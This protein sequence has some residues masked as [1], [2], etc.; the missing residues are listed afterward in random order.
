MEI[1]IEELKRQIANND[2]KAQN[3]LGY[4][5]LHGQ[6]IEQ[7]DR[8][9]YELFKKAA[10]QGLI[11]AQH[12][13]GNCYALGRGTKKNFKKAVDLFSIGA[14]KG[15]DIAVASMENLYKN[16]QIRKYCEEKNYYFSKNTTVALFDILGFSNYVK[17]NSTDKIVALYNKLVSIINKV[18][19]RH[20]PVPTPISKDWKQCV[21]LAG[22]KGDVFTTYSSD[23][24][25]IWMNT[26]QN[27]YKR[28]GTVPFYLRT[29]YHEPY[30]LMVAEADNYNQVFYDNHI[31]YIYFLEVCLEFF[32][33][34]LKAG[35]PLRGCI[36]TGNAYFDKDKGIY[37][38][39]SLVE[40]ARGEGARRSIGV[41]FGASFAKFHPVFPRFYIPNKIS[42]SKHREFSSPF[43]LDWA[44]Y[45][46]RKNED[47]DCIKLIEEMCADENFSVYYENAKEFYKFSES[48]ADWAAEVNSKSCTSMKDYFDNVEQWLK[49]K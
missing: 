19:D 43:S 15:Y 28:N 31:Y 25:V 42:V 16:R 26:N 10:A 38:G 22:V 32:C 44:R 23:T 29:M 33:E 39:E 3:E 49:D 36:S 20:V 45:W 1:T 24:F 37:I 9:A 2:P 13:L 8:A 4:R 48:N 46:R 14:L 35:I 47:L 21:C 30:P 7:N 5:Y 40:A 6:D 41:D 11:E 18:P 12:N 34:A 27:I 17:T